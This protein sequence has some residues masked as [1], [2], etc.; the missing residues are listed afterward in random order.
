[1]AM[2][3]SC[4]GTGILE[5]VVSMTCGREGSG[6]V[7]ELW[8]KPL[9]EQ[10]LALFGPVRQCA[11]AHSVHLIGTFQGSMGRMASSSSPLSRR[12][13]LL[14]Q[15]QSV[16]PP[17]KTLQNHHGDLVPSL[18]PYTGGNFRAC[19]LSRTTQNTEHSHFNW[20]HEG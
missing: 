17:K 2:A 3:C 10:L 18:S 19:D 5:I 16:T 7:P 13:P 1:M 8:G 15:K 11:S 9:W 6:M 20:L 14:L 12:S 4:V